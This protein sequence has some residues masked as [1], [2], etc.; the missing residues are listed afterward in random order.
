MDMSIVG[1]RPSP[2]VA[3][4]YAEAEGYRIFYREAGPVDGPTILLLHGFPS[5]S[6]MF[7]ELIPALADKY[8]VI[9]PDMLG[10]GFSDTPPHTEYTYTFDNL[11]RTMLAFTK[12]L[13]IGRHVLYLHDYGATVG[14]RMAMQQPEKVTAIV[15]QNGCAYEEGFKAPEWEWALSAY[16]EKSHEARE[17]FRKTLTQEFTKYQY[18][19]GVADSMRVPPETYTLDYALMQ[20]PGNNEI[21]IDL[22]IDF[23]SELDAYPRYQEYFRKYQPPLLAVWGAND[24]WFHKSAAEAFKRDLPS[25]EIRLFESGHFALESH[26]IEIAAETRRFLDRLSAENKLT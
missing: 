12:A 26:P 13:G 14:F 16:R 17:I 11:A 20:R 7:R 18:C 24:P 5:S 3:Y 19:E 1:L 21:Q 22:L 4:R 23:G 10:Y 8:H 6:F 15:S 25:A 9:A 2:S